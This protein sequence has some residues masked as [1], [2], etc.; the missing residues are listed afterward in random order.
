MILSSILM[1]ALFCKALIYYK[2][3]FDA[4]DSVQGLKGLNSLC[5]CLMVMV[6]RLAFFLAKAM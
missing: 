2:E 1:T 4:D 3:K 6:S 5:V